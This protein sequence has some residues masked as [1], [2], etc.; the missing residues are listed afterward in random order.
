MGPAMYQKP[1]SPANHLFLNRLLGKELKDNG[2]IIVVS[3]CV[4]LIRERP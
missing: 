1:E 2:L 3:T 4:T